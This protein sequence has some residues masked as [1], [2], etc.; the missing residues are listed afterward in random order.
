M[1]NWGTG[2]FSDDEAC[3]IRDEFRALIAGG[4][5]PRGAVTRLAKQYL[6]RASDDCER[7]VFWMALA[8]TAWRCGR[9]TPLLRRRALA[10]IAK[11]GD[12]QRWED[13]APELVPKRKAAFE[14]LRGQLLSPQPP[15]TRIPKTYRH[16]FGWRPGDAIAFRVRSGRTVIMRVLGIDRYR[17]DELP[18]MDIAQWRGR[19]VPDAKTIAKAPRR[20]SLF[21]RRDLRLTQRVD[22]RA[23]GWVTAHDGKFMLCAHS[24]RG[25][26]ED[27]WQRVAT[28]MRLK[29]EDGSGAFLFDVAKLDEELERLFGLK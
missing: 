8:A 1:G 23:V 14:A 28:G 25:I 19:R 11:G 9:L 2:L 29:K 7:A 24:R 13:D 12:I 15:A 16:N 6:T 20:R 21:F 4:L 27:R 22:P 10:C 3:D 17:A 5:E 18:V 26:P